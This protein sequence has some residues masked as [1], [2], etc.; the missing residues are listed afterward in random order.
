M[1]RDGSSSAFRNTSIAS[2]PVEPKTLSVMNARL[3]ICLY[4]ASLS[5]VVRPRKSTLY[6][7]TPLPPFRLI[8]A[9]DEVIER[10]IEEVSQGD[11]DERRRDDFSVFVFLISLFRYTNSIGNLSL[12][13]VFH[14]SAS[15]ECFV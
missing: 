12:C 11:E 1:D 13:K 4:T 5:A 15:F 2:S 9:A 8:G 3:S 7:F 6:F 14:L 10:N